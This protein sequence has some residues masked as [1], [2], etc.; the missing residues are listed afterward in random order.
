MYEMEL[1][2][3][4]A[5]LKV[6]EDH[7]ILKFNA[8][9]ELQ[10]ES[11]LLYTSYLL[12]LVTLAFGISCNNED[13]AEHIGSALLHPQVSID[14]SAVAVDGSVSTNLVNPVPSVQQM[15]LKVT[16]MSTGRE[17]QWKSVLDYPMDNSYLPGKYFVE[18]AY[19]DSIT[20]VSYTHLAQVAQGNMA[21]R[22]IAQ[23]ILGQSSEWLLK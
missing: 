5:S 10:G 21:V 20:A 6:D 17:A 13:Y 18:T 22:M 7:Y 23:T 4:I 15:G 2:S 12:I 19:G 9:S 14:A 8:P 1:G 16:N 3:Q 11:C